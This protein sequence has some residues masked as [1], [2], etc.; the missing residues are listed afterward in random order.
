MRVILYRQTHEGLRRK[1]AD[2]LRAE[3][4]HRHVPSANKASDEGARARPFVGAM[5]RPAARWCALLRDGAPCRA[6]ARPAA[7]WCALPRDG[8]PCRAIGAM[9]PPLLLLHDDR[10]GWPPAG[11]VR[12]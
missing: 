7:R 12:R 10:P 6:M 9:G 5:A 2:G 8:A 3:L 11:R 4:A 1:I